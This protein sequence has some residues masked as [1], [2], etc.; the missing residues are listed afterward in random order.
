[1]RER[2]DELVL[3]LV[4][5]AQ[6]LFTGTECQR[7]GVACGNLRFEPC[8]GLLEFCRAHGDF[9]GQ[10]HGRL[11]REHTRHDEQ[12]R[13]GRAGGYDRR[14]GLEG[15]TEAI[16]RMP[17]GP[18]V[19]RVCDAAEQDECGEQHR[20]PGVPDFVTTIP[21]VVAD[22]GGNHQIRERDQTIAAHIQPEDRRLPQIAV[23]MRHVAVG[24]E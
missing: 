14:D 11:Q 3:P 6:A 17:D 19:E 9:A 15:A 1:M 10:L 13:R 12:Q 24:L 7:T 2:G 23:A 20:D 16:V 18:D 22:D 5:H 8:C 4:L 21:K